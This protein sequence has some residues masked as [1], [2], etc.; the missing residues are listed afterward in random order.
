[1]FMEALDRR[2]TK[3]SEGQSLK[4]GDNS[5]LNLQATYIADAKHL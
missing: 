2:W 3:S 5:Q 4:F 1:M